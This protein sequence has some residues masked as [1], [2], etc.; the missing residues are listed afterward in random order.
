MTLN[1]GSDLPVTSTGATYFVAVNIASDAQLFETIGLEIEDPSTDITFSDVETDSYVSIQ[2]TQEGYITSSAVTPT[3]DNTVLIQGGLSIQEH[4]SIAPSSIPKGTTDTGMAMLRFTS[5]ELGTQ[6][7]SSI[8]LRLTG[9]T[10]TTDIDGIK[11]YYEAEGGNGLFDRGGGD[12]VDALSGGPYTFDAG[13]T[14]TIILNPNT[15]KFSDTGSVRLYAAFDMNANADTSDNVG[16]EIFEVVWGPDGDGTGNTSTAPGD[17]SLH[18]NTEEVDDYETTL[19]ATGIAPAEATQSEQRVGIFQLDFSVIDTSVTANINSIRLHR[20]GTGTDAD[21]ATGGVILF[22]DSGTTP[23]SFDAGDQ[24]VTAGSLSGGYALLDPAA[25]LPLT[26]SGATYYV[27]INLDV[28]AQVGETVGLEIED[29]STDID[30]N[31]TNNNPYVSVQYTQEGYIT[32]STATPSSG[33]TVSILII[34]DTVA[35]TV[36]YTDPTANE[37]SAPIDTE[38]IAVFSEEIDPSTVTDTTFIVRDTYNNQIQGTVAANVNQAV[39]TPDSDLEYDTIYTCQVVGGASGITDLYANPLESDFIWSFTT[40]EDVPKPVAANNR[41]LPGST[42]PVKIYIPQPSGGANEK[43][44]VQVYTVTGKKVATLVSNRTYAQIKSQ[45]PLL[46]Y[47]KN[48]RNQDLG[49][50]LYFIQ[51]MSGSDKTVLKVLIVR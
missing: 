4:I 40:R 6:S 9:T 32:S 26:S 37:K 18:G 22:D 33:N 51:V 31:D 49:P 3:T 46:W 42:D 2:Y 30:F 14:K 12:D 7:V 45:I 29:P 47:G 25:N 34:A 36:T 23:G 24:E 44:T 15:V 5:S 41:I 10:A 13:I 38:I 39:F 50:G 8:T 27:A 11:V 1:P 19:T 21:I 16:C 48:G 43:I 35:P 28:A 20:V 17:Y